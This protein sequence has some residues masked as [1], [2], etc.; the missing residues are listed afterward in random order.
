[1]KRL[2]AEFFARGTLM[3]ASFALMAAVSPNRAEDD[4]GVGAAE[5]AKVGEAGI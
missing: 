5:A 3:G 4:G 1:M 2:K